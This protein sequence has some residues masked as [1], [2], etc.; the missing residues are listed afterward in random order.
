MKNTYPPMWIRVVEQSHYGVWVL[1]GYCENFSGTFWSSRFIKG[2]CWG[3][4]DYLAIFRSCLRKEY[5]DQVIKMLRS[6]EGEHTRSTYRLDWVTKEALDL[7]AKQQGPLCVASLVDRP[8]SHAL[9]SRIMTV[10]EHS[11]DSDTGNLQLLFEIG[12]FI[13]LDEDFVGDLST[14]GSDLNSRPPHKFVSVYDNSWPKF[15]ESSGMEMLDS[16]RRSINFATSSWDFTNSVFLRPAD[17]KL[18]GTEKEIF[19]SV[20]QASPIEFEIASYNPHL[21]D[22][23]LGQKQI[24]VTSGGAIA[25]IAKPPMID[26]DGIMS[27]NIKFLEPGAATLEIDVRPDPQFSAYIP[28]RLEIS[29]DPNSDPVGPRIL[30]PD[31]SHCLDEIERLFQ[32]DSPKLLQILDQLSTAFPREPEVM[33]RIGRIH[34]DMG[35]FNKARDNFAEVLKIR[36]SSRGV[37]WSLIAALKVDAVQEAEQILDRLNLSANE[38]FEQIVIAGSTVSEQTAI[39]FIDAPG[40]SMSEDKAIKL[41]LALGS[42]VKSHEGTRVVMAAIA[43]LSKPVALQF[44]RERLSHNSEWRALRRDYVE[45]AEEVGFAEGVQDQAEILLRYEDELPSEIIDRVDRLGKLIHPTRLLNVLMYNASSFFVL[46]D[47][48]ART[49]GIDQAA[50][51]AQ[52]AFDLGDYSTADFAIQLVFANSL[53]GDSTSLGYSSAVSQIASRINA[54]RSEQLNLADKSDSYTDF[55]LGR[56]SS[57]MRDKTLV[58]IGGGNNFGLLEHWKQQLGLKEFRWIPGSPTTN[59]ECDSLL[60]FDPESLVVVTIW[61]EFWQMN[62]RVND[63]LGK[64]DVP[65]GRAFLDSESILH[66]LISVVIRPEIED[67]GDDIRRCRGAVDTARLRL[68]HIVLNPGIDGI[69]DD[70]DQFPLAKVWAKKIW[71]SLFALNEYAKWRS[72][73]QSSGRDFYSWLGTQSDLIPPNWV[74]MKESEGLAAQSKF[75]KARVFPVDVSVDPAGEVFMEAHVKIDHDHPAPRIHFYDASDKAPYKIFVGYVG[76]HLPTP[77]GH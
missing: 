8:G 49:A 14:W 56:L 75:Y 11:I 27:I 15:R 26:R 50:R 77:S 22:V 21:T 73:T 34:L 43:D 44:A 45:L 55:L 52:L 25:D 66:A 59:S 32:N 18:S 6:V 46:D 64:E 60:E 5:K 10:L 35:K 23:A 19:M 3:F 16:W 48:S 39:R 58:V 68:E 13:T 76:V 71:R 1:H 69:V 36:E 51:A 74:S 38:L 20:D 30:G 42:A 70:L 4:M 72:S 33:L 29:A 7:L 40:L 31:W 2:F 61:S 9:P 63:W 54:I 53:H 47:E 62:A 65:V 17:S 67:Y 37:A 57:Y 28:I 12:P 24:Q 41:V